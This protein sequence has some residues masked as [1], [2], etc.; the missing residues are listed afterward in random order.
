MPVVAAP[1]NVA[2]ALTPE[3]AI[4]RLFTQ[5]QI[6]AN[7]FTE[8]FLTA[9][10]VPQIQQIV[11][12]L[13]TALGKYQTVRREGRDY[14]VEFE[15]GSVP[16][17]ITLN[18]QQ[19]IAG[20]LFESP[21]LK[22]ASLD[23]ALRGF[24]S[25]PGQV[26][27]LVTEGETEK[28][29]LQADTPLAVGSTFK[30]AVLKALQDQ[31]AAGQK[32]WGDVVALKPEW[33]SLPSGILQT[34]TDGA[35]L[36][37]DSLAALMISQSDNTATDHLMRLVG[38]AAIAP[39]ADRNQPFLTTREFFVLKSA[40][41][42]DL[43]AQY[44]TGDAAKRRSLLPQVAQRPLPDGREFE[45][46]PIAQDVEWFFTTR[47][48]CALMAQVQDLPLMTINPGVTNAA[49]WQRVAF[50]GGSESGVVNLTTGLQAKTGKRYCVSATWNNTAVLERSQF[51]ALYSGVVERL[52]A[53]SESTSLK[54]PGL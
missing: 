1:A 45:G 9:A 4:E 27:L 50:K 30:L 52:R 25:L 47:E 33:K 6:Q 44:R 34:W 49:N 23:E 41:N 8:D 31:V 19:Q 14:Q 2:Q 51:F 46:D 5:P 29:A 43:L 16:T 26:S 22:F 24:R 21:R 37:L 28:A 17:K 36:T 3:A 35:L 40:Q 32:Q 20:L 10:P 13:Q 11:A 54:Q 42:A 12:S 53:E 39:L 15:R 18:A 7:W 48:L 38:E